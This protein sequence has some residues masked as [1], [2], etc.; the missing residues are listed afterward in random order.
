MV[1]FQP[2]L[3][4]N[5]SPRRPPCGRSPSPASGT[6]TPTGSPPGR[7]SSPHPDGR[8]PR[9]AGTSPPDPSRRWRSRSRAGRTP[10]ARH[11]RP[12]GRRRPC[13]IY[14][15]STAPRGRCSGPVRRPA[16]LA[17][18]LEGKRLAG[19]TRCRHVI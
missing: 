2:G 12:T 15:P 14:R 8:A 11:A 1:Y 9:P 7:C 10:R 16:A 4:L 6:D 13:P 17:G 3:D 18:S 5:R 19:S